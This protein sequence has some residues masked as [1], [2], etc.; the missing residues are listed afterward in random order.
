MKKLLLSLLFIL[1]GGGVGVSVAHFYPAKWQVSAQF[2]PPKMDE[3]GNYFSLFSTYSLV[4][5]DPEA[6]DMSKIERKATQAA[7]E[8]FTQ[9]LTSPAQLSTYLS[10]SNFVKSL[11][12]IEGIGEQTLAR[13]IAED[14]SL[15]E[16][17]GQPQLSLSAYDRQTVDVL[18][19][20]YIRHI[21][22]Q[23]RET[24]NKGLIDKWKLLFNQVKQAADA[25]IDVSWE[26]KLKMMQ[27]VQPL[28]NN[29]VAFHFARP[30]QLSRQA[31]PSLTH[32]GAQA[33]RAWVCC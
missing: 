4:S 28:D 21:N 20:D 11:A 32:S 27:S 23:A 17:N 24:L 15:S 6:V 3:L 19:V 1:I 12:Q 30:P 22:Q 7:Y 2:Q 10:Q 9:L 14:F 16:Q 26:N 5:G 33:V 31:K 29:L 18:F 8:T 13:Q 25:K